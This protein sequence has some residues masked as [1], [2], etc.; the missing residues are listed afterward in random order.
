VSDAVQSLAKAKLSEA[1]LRTAEAM[2][3]RAGQGSAKAEHGSAMRRRKAK[4]K[5]GRL[6]LCG[7]KA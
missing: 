5:L 2:L 7:A 3:T 6:R 1:L 4:A